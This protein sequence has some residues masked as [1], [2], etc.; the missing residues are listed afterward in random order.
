MAYKVTALFYNALRYGWYYQDP[1]A[2][3]DNFHYFCQLP[4]ADE[5]SALPR[6][7]P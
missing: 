6:Q 3:Y 2:A 1:G 5:Q 4:T 7:V